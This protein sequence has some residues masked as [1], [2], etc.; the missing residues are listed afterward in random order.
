M[1]MN[2]DNEQHS[3]M[4]EPKLIAEDL[5]NF[6][7]NKDNEQHSEMIEPKL[8]AE[9]LHTNDMNKDNEQHCEMIEPKKSNIGNR[10]LRGN[11]K[12]AALEL[13]PMKKENKYLG[14]FNKNQKN[15]EFENGPII[16]P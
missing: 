5:H 8:I 7:M 4:I 3:E 10:K 6:D 1:G 13:K 14:R 16:L 12:Q 11:D 9:D 15:I 2:K